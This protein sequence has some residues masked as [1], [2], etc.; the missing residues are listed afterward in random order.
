MVLRIGGLHT[1][2][3]FLGSI[4]HIMKNS[5]LTEVLEVVYGSNTVTHMLSGKALSRA[6]RG[7]FLVNAALNIILMSGACRLPLPQMSDHTPLDDGQLSTLPLVYG[8]RLK[9]SF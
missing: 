1:E 5:G 7:H 9:P 3:S 6:R 4:G 8:Q 2:M